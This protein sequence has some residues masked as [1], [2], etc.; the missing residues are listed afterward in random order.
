MILFPLKLTA[1]TVKTGIELLIHL[2]FSLYDF[3]VS[4]VGVNITR[5]EIG[6]KCW[7]EVYTDSIKSFKGDI[8]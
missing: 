8:V 1:V 2:D 4:Q 7:Y 6:K 5:I 3:S